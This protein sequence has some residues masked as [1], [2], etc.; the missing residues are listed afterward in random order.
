MNVGMIAA[1]IVGLLVLAQ[2]GFYPMPVCVAGAV[3]LVIVVVRIAAGCRSRALLQSRQPGYGLCIF[4]CQYLALAFLAIAILN[5]ASSLVHG[6]G[7]GSFA[8]AA[9]WLALAVFAVLCGGIPCDQH[10]MALNG[11]G[12]FVVVTAVV[13]IL[14][15]AGVL[16]P[17]GT[18][19]AGR[20]CILFE[21]S[22][23][24]GI[25]FGMGALVL[26]SSDD[27]R[28]R[29]LGVLPLFALLLTKSV[30]AIVVTAVALAVVAIWGLRRH[31]ELH[32]VLL[33]AS[34]VGAVGSFAV[35]LVMPRVGAAAVVVVVAVML[36]FGARLKSGASLTRV[37]VLV[38]G[39][40]T[41]AAVVGVL[42]WEPARWAQA[43]ETFAE[44]LVQMHDGLSLLVA[45]PWLGVGPGQWAEL[46]GD[47]QTAD[48]IATVNHCSYLQMALDGGI[49]APVIFAAATGFAVVQC[50]RRGNFL[51]AMAGAML[52]VHSIFDFDL[53]FFA[54]QF[55]LVLLVSSANDDVSE[56][57]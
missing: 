53:S 32:A 16:P 31:E 49:V 5:L 6:L 52:L 19:A 1:I 27:G 40:L 57:H 48:Y 37:V 11:L 22:N 3:T 38:A 13:G 42:V 17:E 15:A 47:V 35:Y 50:A 44:R 54:L 34:W 4:R 33:A 14:A 46:Y 55:F 26:A 8:M 20:L 10:A 12:W 41:L 36:G 2:G 51:W 18:M 21:Y 7:S 25:W 29:S 24:T 28:L 56:R 43:Q 30:G 45:Q 9:C 39:G 23:A